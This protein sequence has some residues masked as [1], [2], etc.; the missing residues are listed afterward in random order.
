MDLVHHWVLHFIIS[1]L[2]FSFVEIRTICWNLCCVLSSVSKLR[3]YNF[4]T[5]LSPASTSIEV[6]CHLSSLFWR[7]YCHWELLLWLCVVFNWALLSRS[8]TQ[9]VQGS[10]V[11]VD[12]W[13][14]A[15]GHHGWQ[16]WGWQISSDPAVHVWRG[17]LLNNYLRGKIYFKKELK[18]VECCLKCYHIRSAGHYFMHS[19]TVI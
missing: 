1:I 14:R 17:N 15:Q 11:A 5:T 6:N 19:S 10:S 18:P 9:N 16:R 8:S 7:F 4:T 2:A 12:G 13:S 3:Y